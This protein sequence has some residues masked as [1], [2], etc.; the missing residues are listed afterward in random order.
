[1]CFDVHL[2]ISGKLIGLAWLLGLSGPFYLDSFV[3]DSINGLCNPVFLIKLHTN[4][5]PLH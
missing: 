1:M 5:Y 3:Y 4:K 2:A